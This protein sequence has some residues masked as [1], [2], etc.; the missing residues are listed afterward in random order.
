MGE[1]RD[2]NK[3]F[4]RCKYL[5]GTYCELID[6]VAT[7]CRCGEA[8]RYC[9]SYEPAEVD[10][11]KLRSLKQEI[12]R[13]NEELQRIP[14]LDIDW[15]SN[16]EVKKWKEMENKRVI[17]EEMLDELNEIYARLKTRV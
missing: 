17:L 10:F 4:P 3:F 1:I 15:N 12:E 13:I 16:E 2:T 11:K 7:P 5:Q 6:D 8:Y 14:N 9:G